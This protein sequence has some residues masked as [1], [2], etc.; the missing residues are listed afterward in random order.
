MIEAVSHPVGYGKKKFEGI[1]SGA[2][3]FPL[4]ILFSI[5]FFDEFDTAAFNTLAPKIQHA[6]HLSDSGFVGIT[7]KVSQRG[8]MLADK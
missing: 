4:L 8:R 2:L 1:T 5:Y 7:G 6:F 3:V